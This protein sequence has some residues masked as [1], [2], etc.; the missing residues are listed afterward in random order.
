MTSRTHP[1]RSPWRPEAHSRGC[2]FEVQKQSSLEVGVR[3]VLKEFWLPSLADERSEGFEN[4]R[5]SL[6]SQ[7][8]EATKE[9]V[10]TY[11]RQTIGQQVQ[12]VIFSRPT[13][14]GPRNARANRN[15]GHALLAPW[16]SVQR[17]G[18]RNLQ[19]C[20]PMHLLNEP[21]LRSTA[22]TVKV[23]GNP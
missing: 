21:T 3:H 13:D 5:D 23:L 19:A 20:G 15:R 10:V 6:L 9:W 7:L 16:P 18:L 4:T 1:F 2:Y 22:A 12:M 14:Q 17:P 11:V 8:Q